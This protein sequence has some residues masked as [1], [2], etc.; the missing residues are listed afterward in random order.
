M[1]SIRSGTRSERFVS[2]RRSRRH[3][4]YTAVYTDL[5]TLTA[6]QEAAIEAFQR[7]LVV[8]RNEKTSRATLEKLLAGETI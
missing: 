7:A 2:L 1:A 3:P 4:F 6:D 8:D 5:A